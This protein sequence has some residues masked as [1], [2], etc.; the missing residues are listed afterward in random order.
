MRLANNRKRRVEAAE[1]ADGQLGRTSDAGRV[2]SKAV[3]GS[4]ASLTIAGTAF[5]CHYR[6]TT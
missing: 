3:T 6:T 2:S 4:N 5:A 1:T